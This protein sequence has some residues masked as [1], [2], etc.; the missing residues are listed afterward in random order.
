MN[1]FI[2]RKGSHFNLV[3]CIYLIFTIITICIEAHEQTASKFSTGP[4]EGKA[5]SGG[6]VI[7]FWYWQSMVSTLLVPTKVRKVFVDLL[8]KIMQK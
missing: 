2:Q 3:L 7:F 1:S 4:N 8:A 6:D 5:Q